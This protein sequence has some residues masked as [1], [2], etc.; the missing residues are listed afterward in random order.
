MERLL[1]DPELLRLDCIPL[2]PEPDMNFVLSQEAPS[3]GGTSPFRKLE[4]NAL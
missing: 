3:S 1:G 2:G 4:W